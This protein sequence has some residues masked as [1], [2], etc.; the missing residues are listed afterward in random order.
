MRAQEKQLRLEPCNS[1]A[2]PTTEP[3][4]R[5]D[6]LWFFGFAGHARAGHRFE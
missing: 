2:H 1:V 4:L 6:E 3:K 5:S